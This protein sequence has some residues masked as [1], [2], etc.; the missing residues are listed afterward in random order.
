MVN[1]HTFR[2]VSAKLIYFICLHLFLTLSRNIT[3]LVFSADR[4]TTKFERTKIL[5]RFEKK[6][7]ALARKRSKFKQKL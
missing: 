7:N 2:V 4:L 1:K 3:N 6:I 5:Y